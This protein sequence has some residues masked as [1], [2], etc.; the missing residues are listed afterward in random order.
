MKGGYKG[1]VGRTGA[2]AAHTKICATQA[3][4]RASPFKYLKP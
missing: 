3:K 1:S 4:N 2:G